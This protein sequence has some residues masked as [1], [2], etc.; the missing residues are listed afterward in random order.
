VNAATR[1][2]SASAP[3]SVSKWRMRSATSRVSWATTSMK[4]SS[5][6]HG[7]T[8]RRSRTPMFFIARTV[9]AMLTGFCGS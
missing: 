1:T 7:R 3:S 8:S 6:A 4:F 2:Q 5:Y 9:A